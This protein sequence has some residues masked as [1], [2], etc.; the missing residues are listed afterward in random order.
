MS[1]IPPLSTHPI[2][3]NWHVTEACNFRC[4]YCYAEW[5]PSDELDL[6]HDPAKTRTLLESLYEAFGTMVPS[7][8]RLNFAGGE[9]LLKEKHV[10]PAMRL[11]REIGFDVSLISNGSRLD[12][13]LTAALAPEISLLGLSIDAESPR[14]LA[15]IGRQDHRGLQVD[16]A[17][18]AQRIAQARRINPDLQVK[19]NTVVCAANEQ[20]DLSGVIRALSPQRWKVLRMLP[21]I[22]RALQVSDEGFR[23]FV[24][25]HQSLASL[26]T[27]EDNDDMVGSYIMIDPTG[28]FFQNRDGMPGYDYSPPICEVGAGAAFDRIGWSAVKFNG[29]YQRPLVKEAT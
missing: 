1:A 11:A 8:P 2:V 3:I 19:V 29:R 22:G 18:L 6:I 14:V 25:R 24:D 26:M 7:R 15:A 13:R 4:R 10:L 20:E 21:A 5:Q 17:E 16:L 27:V 23:A 9:P 12:H 28:R